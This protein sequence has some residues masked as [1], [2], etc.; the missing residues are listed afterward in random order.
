MGAVPRSSAGRPPTFAGAPRSVALGGRRRRAAPGHGAQAALRHRPPPPHRTSDTPAAAT[1]SEAVTTGNWR[2]GGRFGIFLI[3]LRRVLDHTERPTSR[4]SPLQPARY[5]ARSRRRTGELAR[6]PQ[7][8]AQFFADPPLLLG[9]LPPPHMRG[10]KLP[11]PAQTLYPP[12]CT[13]GS[14]RLVG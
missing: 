7:Q 9:G 5:R 1:I 8:V 12:V 14:V 13:K 4:D 6:I 10:E 2:L 3:V 11:P